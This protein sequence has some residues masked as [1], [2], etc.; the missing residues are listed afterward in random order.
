[1][2]R[3]TILRISAI[4]SGISGVV[5][6]VGVIYPI[7]SYK[8][9][10][11]VSPVSENAAV[12]VKAASGSETVDY[13]QASNWFPTAAKK[14]DFVASKV[15]YYTISIPRLKIDNASVAIGGEDLSKS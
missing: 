13:T 7:V 10:E 1:M 14:E 11:L 12:N 3:K 4:I 8:S 2:T 9:P 15:S 6:L 5:I